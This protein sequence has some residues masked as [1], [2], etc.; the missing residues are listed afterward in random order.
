MLPDLLWWLT[1]STSGLYSYHEILYLVRLPVPTY[2]TVPCTEI[3]LLNERHFCQFCLHLCNGL[4]FSY[5]FLGRFNNFLMR[6]VRHHNHVYQDA[7][8]NAIFIHFYSIQRFGH[9]L[10]RA[11]GF[12]Q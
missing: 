1:V 5:R 4:V 7:V 8:L 11:E 3:L 12:R 9:H 10:K 6:C 2:Q